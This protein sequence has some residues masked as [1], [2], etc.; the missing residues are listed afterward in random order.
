MLHRLDVPFLDASARQLT[1]ALDAP[2]QPA[3]ATLEVDLPRSGGRPA[4]RVELRLLGASHQVLVLDGADRVRCN[5]LVACRPGTDHGPLPPAVGRDLDGLA[6]RFASTVEVVDAATMAAAARRLVG[7][8]QVDGARRLVG[9]FP[10]DPH[11]LT[12]IHATADG[13]HTWHLYPQSGE[14]VTTRTVLA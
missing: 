13:W 7:G 14:L 10:G 5:E 2:P 6:Y 8:H 4:L 9:A 12:A 3:L 1:W 11:A